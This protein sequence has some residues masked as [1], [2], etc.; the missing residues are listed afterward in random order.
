MELKVESLSFLDEATYDLDGISIF[1]GEGGKEAI[2]QLA[3][4]SLDSLFDEAGKRRLAS[5]QAIRALVHYYAK[6][7]FADEGVSASTHGDVV[8]HQMRLTF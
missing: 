4:A 8:W 6:F 5:L 3:K 1:H 7:G 2:G